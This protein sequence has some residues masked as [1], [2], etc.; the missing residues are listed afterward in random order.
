MKT[1][2]KIIFVGDSGTC[3]GPM[4]E[5]IMKEYR[6]KR[7]MEI[8]SRGLVALFPEPMNQ[9]AEAVLISN[10]ITLENYVSVQLAEGDFAEDT[11]V[12]VMEAVHK[13]RILNN[14][15]GVNPE[16]VQVLTEMV[17]EELEII[18]PYGGMLP[19]YG[20]CFETLNRTIKKL[21]DK[22]NEGE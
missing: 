11:L 21:V 5:A 16:N 13:E 9:K 19:T 15:Q 17:G 4:A 12:I 14:F 2:N 8:V 20:L 10:G 18:N 3:R 1:Y 22:M 7:P 6:L